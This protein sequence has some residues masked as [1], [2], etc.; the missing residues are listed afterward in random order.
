MA[1]CACAGVF[2]DSICL[3]YYILHISQHCMQQHISCTLYSQIAS[4]LC[5]FFLTIWLAVLYFLL[6]KLPKMHGCAHCS[7]VTIMRHVNSSR[8]QS[9]A[10]QDHFQRSSS[11]VVSSRRATASLFLLLHQPQHTSTAHHNVTGL[12]LHSPNPCATCAHHNNNSGRKH[13]DHQPGHH[14][15][16]CSLP[17]RL[18]CRAAQQ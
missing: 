11:S 18:P 17:R 10:P 16:V 9:R 14:P 7:N 6:P 3:Y 13:R 15:R 1:C 2:A 4:V 12:G 5:L 8:Q